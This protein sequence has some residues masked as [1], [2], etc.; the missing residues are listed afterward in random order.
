MKRITALF[1]ALI[2]IS[3][4]V[5]TSC[6]TDLVEPNDSKQNTEGTPSQSEAPTEPQTETPQEFV[7]VIVVDNDNCKV[8][9]TGIESDNF[10]GYTLN[11]Y[12][13]NKSADTTYAFSINNAAINGIEVVPM[14]LC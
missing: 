10:L 3:A 11:V 14:F 5:M 12:L 13:E 8:E 1:L 7:N 9:I 6:T 2:L 4:L